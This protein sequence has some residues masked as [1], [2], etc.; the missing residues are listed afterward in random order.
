[1]ND[2]Y[3]DTFNP[4]FEIYKTATHRLNPLYKTEPLPQHYTQTLHATHYTLHT[5][6]RQAYRKVTT[7]HNTLHTTHW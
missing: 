1:M 2:T 6:R 5:D 4:I 3:I 7:T